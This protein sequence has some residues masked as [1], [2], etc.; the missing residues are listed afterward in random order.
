M[1]DDHLVREEVRFSLSFVRSLIHSYSGLYVGENL[2]RDVLRLCDE[3]TTAGEPDARIREAR[4]IVEDRCRRLVRA[5]DRFT[6]RDPA[7]I[8][9]A[10]AQTVAAVDALQDAVVRWRKVHAQVPH[11]GRLLKRKSA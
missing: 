3:M 9:S 5:A 10:R 11:I 7:A 6:E 8:A 4:S 2:T 1:D